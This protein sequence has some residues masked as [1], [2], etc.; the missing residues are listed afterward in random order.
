MIGIVLALLSAA[1]SGLSVVLVRRNSGGS[2]AF[3]V[4]LIITM[5][6]MVFLWPL[7][8]ALTSFN[9]IN[10]A[11]FALFAVSGVL[12]PGLV[13]LFYY[14]GL[15]KLGVSVNSSIYAAYPL[16]S[17]LLAVLFLSEVLSV[18]NA[19]GILTI[20]AGIVIADWSIDRSNGKGGSG[21]RSLVFPVI[22]G[23]ILGISSVIRK[24]ALDLS[25]V[26]VFGVAVAY[27]FSFL[28]YV[29]ILASSSQT[30]EGLALKQNLR[31]FWAA[32]IGQGVTWLLAFY[33]LSL[34][35][36]SV[37]TPLL[38]IEPLFVAVLAF[39]YLKKL[40]TVSTKLLAGIIVTVFGVALI[41]L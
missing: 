30:R 3:N 26:P 17:A 4:S 1:A 22:G 5:I 15:K 23:V 20:L 7:A 24:F 38:S 40:E 35:Q 31:W 41:A 32:G 11:G 13:R 6:G 27:T 34:D 25:N 21:W 2:N 8:I 18:W 36:V 14:Q 16:Y 28:P 37:I 19:L 39:F 29:L 12:S 9:S 33:A 10:I